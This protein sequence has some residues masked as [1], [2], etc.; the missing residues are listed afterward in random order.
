MAM[1]ERQ[2]DYVALKSWQQR[3]IARHTKKLDKLQRC[4]LL[5]LNDL[6]ERQRQVF[7]LHYKEGLTVTQVARTLGLHR[8]TVSRT[9]ARA[10][11][12][13]RAAIRYVE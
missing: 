11:R 8:S 1:T 3:K 13:L 5:L 9:L 2:L 7:L 10:E 6:T 4:M 12:K